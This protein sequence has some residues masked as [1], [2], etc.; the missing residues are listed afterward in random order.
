MDKATKNMKKIPLIMGGK[1]VA[2]RIM[3]NKSKEN[4]KRRVT[5]NEI[6]GKC[7]IRD[8]LINF[9]SQPFTVNEPVMDPVEMCFNGILVTFGVK[10]HDSR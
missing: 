4:Q 10:S 5:Q 3:A 6:P 9:L 1:I 8:R 2:Y 7:I